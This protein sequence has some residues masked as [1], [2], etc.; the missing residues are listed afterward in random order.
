MRSLLSTETNFLSCPA[1]G[2]NSGQIYATGVEG[3]IFRCAACGFRMCTAHDPAIPF[4]EDEVCRQYKERI[5]REAREQDEKRKREQEEASVAEVGCSPVECPCCGVN[6]Q[7][8]AGC[9]HMTC[10]FAI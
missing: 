4:H 10:K 6:I 3:P 5:K 2:C 9:D 1:E 7:K 8:T